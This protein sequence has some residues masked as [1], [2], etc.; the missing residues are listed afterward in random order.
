M[1]G[2]TL[3]NALAAFLLPPGIFVALLAVA[4]WRCPRCRMGLSALL[5]ALYVLAMPIAG[6]RLL[7]S[8]QIAAPLD[9]H[10]PPAADAIVVLGAGRRLDAPEYGG[11]TVNNLTLERL[12]YAARLEAATRLPILVTGGTPGGGREPEGR[13]MAEVLE[14]EYHVPVRWQEDRALT[15]WDNAR[16]SAP[17]L[18]AAGVRRIFLVTHAWHM[19]RA[20]PLFKKA[21]F[22]VIPAGTGFAH[23][24]LDSVMG[25]LPSA[26]GLRDSYFA[27]HEWLGILWYK[28]RG[29]F[30]ATP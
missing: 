19:R 21:G 7:A 27:L 11:D 15:T 23:T 16:N 12:R 10:R 22:A 18:H 3:G 29:L 24:Q 30:Q 14:R 2:F 20:V 4:A 6:G 13:L 28:F 1:L 17:I 25:V 9:L 5:A 8:L 26:Q